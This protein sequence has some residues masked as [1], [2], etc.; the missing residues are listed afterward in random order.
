MTA[1]T[2]VQAPMFARKANIKTGQIPGNLAIWAAI[3]AEMSEFTVMFIAAYLFPDQI[4]RWATL[5]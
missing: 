1:I 5:K 4:A 3:L 2:Q